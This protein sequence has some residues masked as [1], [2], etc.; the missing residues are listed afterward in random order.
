MDRMGLD[1]NSV[2][3]I[4]VSTWRRLLHD[5][6]LHAISQPCAMRWS[7][8]DLL[9]RQGGGV[10]GDKAAALARFKENYAK[11]SDGVKAR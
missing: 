8:A 4:H 5:F 3:I 7:S 11:L 1:K 6:A 2:M 9:T 10:Y